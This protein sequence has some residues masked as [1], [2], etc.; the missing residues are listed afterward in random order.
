MGCPE[1]SQNQLEKIRCHGT[2]PEEDKP[3]SYWQDQRNTLRPLV[4][5]PRYP[6]RL[7]NQHLDPHSLDREENQLH[8]PKNLPHK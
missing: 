6:Y 8:R 7:P 5:V 3:L 2:I 1:Q 4:Q